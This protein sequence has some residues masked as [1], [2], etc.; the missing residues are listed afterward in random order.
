MKNAG[1]RQG[2]F[3]SESDG[4]TYTKET[5]NKMYRCRFVPQDTKRDNREDSFAPTPPLEA[6]KLLRS[7]EVTE[8]I[9]YKEE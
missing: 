8:G 1:K 6:K 4:Q 3:R 9:G 2:V 7:L 5:K